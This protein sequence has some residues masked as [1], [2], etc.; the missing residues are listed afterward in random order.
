[1]L[2][3]FFDWLRRFF[4]ADDDASRH[5]K[6]KALIDLLGFPIVGATACGITYLFAIFKEVI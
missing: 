6:L 1:M 3:S 5:G 4:L 2:T